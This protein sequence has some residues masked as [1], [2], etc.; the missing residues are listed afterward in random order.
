MRISTVTTILFLIFL[1]S[2][3]GKDMP[4][5]RI[6]NP[7]ILAMKIE[8]P[9]VRPGDQIK[10][11]LLV[12]GWG[13][14]QES[15]I[16][17]NWLGA[18]KLGDFG[19]QFVKPYREPLSM[20]VDESI[21]DLP[22]F[23][24]EDREFYNRRGYFTIPIYASL[25]IDDPDR[26]DKKILSAHKDFKL[27]REGTLYGNPSVAEVTVSWELEGSKF[28]RVV[29]NGN[30][31]T[32][33]ADKIPDFAGFVPNIDEKDSDIQLYRW[34][35]SDSSKD[36]P[37]IEVE[38]GEDLSKKLTGENES[39]TREKTVVL[40]LRGVRESLKKGKMLTHSVYFLVRDKKD[41]P[42]SSAE[43][44]HG[45]DFCVINLVFNP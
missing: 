9:E 41:D 17:V 31:I 10:A 20:K 3:Q 28:S 39:G 44:R 40:D 36:D 5:H 38:G 34:Y 23:T 42:S 7:R 4:E 22:I 24:T 13:F 35:F 30:S 8:N 15:E 37:T 45:L 18:E 27:K 32:F 29:T 25:E 26:S 16:S 33:D 21:F 6:V 12:G 14:S 11:K 19:K 43:Y 1:A 2:C